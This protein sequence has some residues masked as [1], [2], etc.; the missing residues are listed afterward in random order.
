MK[1]QGLVAA[2]LLL[3]APAAAEAQQTIRA[4]GPEPGGGSYVATVALGTMAERHLGANFQLQAG[5]TATRSMVAMAQEQI[6]LTLLPVPAVGLLR[7]GRG[8][9]QNLTNAPEYHARLRGMLVWE[10]CAWHFMTY[11]DDGISAM[12]DFE[13]LRVYTGPPGSVA[14]RNLENMILAATGFVAGE[15]Y[16][17]VN[18]DW[19]AGDQAFRDRNID[20]LVR[21]SQVGGTLVEQLSASRDIRLIGFPPMEG[22]PDL[23]AATSLPGN[24]LITIPS[25]L[26]TGV[27]NEEP[28]TA[29]AL[30]HIAGVGLHLDEEFVYQWTRAIWENI[31][32]FY[33]FGSFLRSVDQASA[34]RDMAVPLHPGAYRYYAEAGWDIP[35][36]LIP[37]EAR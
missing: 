34:F 3:L 18:L 16:T 4:H 17:P 8:M 21:S 12:Q 23:Q 13:G 14:K 19:G 10:C 37:P 28:V 24:K 5:Q 36:N 27:I 25:G 30:R 15:D 29:V 32:E 7:D 22:N 20:V 2:T 26:Y 11:A 35:E 1:L 33:E 9:Y 6:D 31:D